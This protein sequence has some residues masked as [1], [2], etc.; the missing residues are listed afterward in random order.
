MCLRDIDTRCIGVGPALGDARC[1][2]LQECLRLALLSTICYVSLCGREAVTYAAEHTPINQVHY[3][4][5]RTFNLAHCAVSSLLPFTFAL[6]WSCAARDF[7]AA[8]GGSF[9]AILRQV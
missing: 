6:G 9:A 5:R 1:L 3:M 2:L 7:D 4:R 8:V